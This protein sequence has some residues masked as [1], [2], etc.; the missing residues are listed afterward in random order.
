MPIYNRANNNNFNYNTL[1]LGVFTLIAAAVYTAKVNEEDGLDAW[2]YGW[3]HH[4]AWL[5]LILCLVG[6]ITT[7]VLEMPKRPI[8]HI[9]FQD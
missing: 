1:I 3:S 8:I 6:V 5:G 9:E 7:F 2:T 4:F